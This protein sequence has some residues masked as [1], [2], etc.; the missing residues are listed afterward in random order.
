[1]IKNPI[2][3][4]SILALPILG[5]LKIEGPPS[6]TPQ[7]KSRLPK[8]TSHEFFPNKPRLNQIFSVMTGAGNIYIGTSG[9]LYSY[10]LSDWKPLRE[11]KPY[12]EG[13]KIIKLALSGSSHLFAVSE[14]KGLFVLYPGETKFHHTGSTLVRDIAIPEGTNQVYCATSHGVDIYEDGR[15]TNQKI[16]PL[17]QYA[18]R[19]ND[20]Q[21]IAH[22]GGAV[23]WLGTSFGVYRMDGNSNFDFLF[24]DFQIIQGNSVINKKGNSPLRGNLFY[25]IYTDSSDPTILFSTNGGISVLRSPDE[26]KNPT[27]W[28]TYT[29][30]HTISRMTDTG[31]QEFPVRGNSSL[32]TNFVKTAVKLGDSLYFGTEEGLVRLKNQ[33]W[34]VYNLENHLPGDRIYDLFAV[35]SISED[36]LYVGTGGGLAVIREPKH[37]S[38]EDKTI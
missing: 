6:E 21:S 23:F 27:A 18:S 35:D 11:G 16:K 30:N 22:Q 38:Q 13:Q 3:I 37:H 14:E 24:A 15:W 9:G 19:P 33:D 34:T 29:G 2:F 28:K 8:I 4:L 32:P 7:A 26:Y 1:M 31:V 10:S 25:E 20:I 12:L 5:C 36:I 17:S